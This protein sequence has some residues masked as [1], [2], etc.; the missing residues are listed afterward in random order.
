MSKGTPVSTL[1]ERKRRATR[2]R[3]LAVAHALFVERGYDGT[4]MEDIAAGADVSRATAFNYFPR[5]EEFLLAW[6]EGRRVIMS[7]L[8]AREEA[9]S[10]HT[11]DRLR[12][13]F[14]SLGAS[15][16][17]N[18][19]EN[20]ALTR[21]WLQAGGPLLPDAYATAT[22]FADTLRYGLSR[23]ELRRD[24]DAEVVG[25]LLLDAY[26][27]ILIRWSIDDQQPPTIL[28]VQL[29]AALELITDGLRPPSGQ[30]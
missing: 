4:T 19:P 26:L 9:Q 16:E 17:E 30:I 25:R 22:V 27:G 29:V 11:I 23:G 24:I 1:R 5:K 2:E 21:A 3:L 12:H 6:V 13:A 28:R 7:D 18:A 15:L 10:V 8:L 14:A 20:R